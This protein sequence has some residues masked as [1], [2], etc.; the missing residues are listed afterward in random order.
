MEKTDGGVF[1]GRCQRVRG[2][3]VAG[4]DRST[5]ATPSSSA[6]A[7]TPTRSSSSAA[8]EDRSQPDE[9][10][11]PA[12]ATATAPT[13]PAPRPA[14]TVVNADGR[15]PE[16]RQDQRHGPRR[17]DRG[18]QGLLRR[19]RPGHRRLLHLR[20]PGRG[21]RRPR[22]RRRRHQL[23]DLRRD[24]HG[25]RR[26]RVRLRGRGRGRRLRRHLRRQR[27]PGRLH[28]RAQQPVAD[29][30]RRDAPTTTSRTPWCS[31]TARSSRGLDHR[32]RRSRRPRWSTP[33]TSASPGRPRG[34]AALCGPDTLD[35]AKVDRQDRG[36][37]PRR[38]R[39]RR[40]ERRG[41]AGRRRRHDPGQPVAEQPRRGLPLGADRPRRPTRTARRSSRYIANQGD[42]ATAAFKLGNITGSAT[43]VPQV[44]GFSSRGPALANGADLLKPDIA[45]PGVSVLAAVA[46]PSNHDRNFDLYSGT[47]MASPHIA[48]LAAF[49][50]GVHPTW[51]PM[52][53][54]SAMMTTAKSVGRRGRH[55]L[56]TPSRRAPA[57]VTP[58]KFFNPGL[59]VH[60]RP[61][62]GARF[63]TGPGTATPAYQPWRRRTS[64]V[65]SLAQGQVTSATSFTRQFPRPCRAPGRSRSRARLHRGHRRASWSSEA[66]R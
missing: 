4:F 20:H 33:S 32:D 61:T 41:Q 47:S 31:A 29:H 49:M 62:G 44:A 14:T 56:A 36:L 52:M 26:G 50:M 43:P 10:I 19:Q 27:R 12:T 7:T 51:T 42:K 9:Y 45:A 15:G 22:R 5:T 53:V 46:P 54:K 23:L 11:S 1:H 3:T 34:D 39:P 25:R 59:F 13:P 28:G 66:P 37:Q 63:I 38:L 48:G 35:P 58:E 21:R 24:R 60:L 40:Q 6:P 2:P 57:M 65:P 55:R 30:G 64:T 18:V 8:R 17:P 16:L